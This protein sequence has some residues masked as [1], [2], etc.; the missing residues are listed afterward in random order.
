V[1]KRSIVALVAVLVVAVVLWLG[2]QAAWN[3]ILAMH[4]RGR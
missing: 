4:G 3:M 1:S 2:G